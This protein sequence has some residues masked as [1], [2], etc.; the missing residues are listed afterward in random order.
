VPAPEERDGAGTLDNPARQAPICVSVFEDN[1]LFTGHFPFADKSELGSTR[2]LEAQKQKL[3]GD[4][5][6]AMLADAATLLEL[7]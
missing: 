1:A 7:P 6:L 3:L 5:A 2:C 4:R